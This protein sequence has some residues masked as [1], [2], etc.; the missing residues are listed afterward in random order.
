M[1]NERQQTLLSYLITREEFTTKEQI[2]KDLEKFYGNPLEGCKNEHT[3]P[4]YTK[5]SKD[6]RA[7]NEA[8]EVPYMVQSSSEGYKVVINY[9]EADK[10]I[11]RTFSEAFRK[12]KRA[13]GLTK[14]T[15]VNYQLKLKD[16]GELELVKTFPVED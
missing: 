12:L 6:V 1:I 9:T 16:D 7:L 2:S 14:K 4:I 5:L 3:S 15:S 8:Q 13:W 11:N 10:L